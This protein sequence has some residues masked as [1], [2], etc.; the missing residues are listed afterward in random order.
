M[1]GEFD[2]GMFINALFS[3]DS[4]P[5]AALH[6][7]PEQLGGKSVV[8]SEATPTRRPIWCALK[9]K[10]TDGRLITQQ[11]KKLMNT[12]SKNTKG[13]SNKSSGPAPHHSSQTST[14]TGR[15]DARLPIDHAL[16]DSNRKLPTQEVLTKLAEALP[17]AYQSAVVVGNWVWVSFETPPA[18]ETRQALAQLGFHW[19]NTRQTWQHPAGKFSL[20]GAGD[21]RDRYGSTPAPEAAM[22]GATR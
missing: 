6:A 21:P 20:H 12:K 14:G 4:P 22:E 19:N 2:L 17:V 5:A 1:G 3:R 9:A 13:T 8:P 7:H 15:T 16:R 10:A 11:K 18:A